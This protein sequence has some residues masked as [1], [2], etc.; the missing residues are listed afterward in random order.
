MNPLG[1][2]QDVFRLEWVLTYSDNLCEKLK[3]CNMQ[4]QIII[5]SIEKAFE[6]TSLSQPQL[7]RLFR[8]YQIMENC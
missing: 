1:F 2:K 8:V 5:E 7:K 3:E 4:K 6:G